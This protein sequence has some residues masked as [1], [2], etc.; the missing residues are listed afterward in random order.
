MTS[1]VLSPPSNH[2]RALPCSLYLQ[3]CADGGHTPDRWSRSAQGHKQPAGWAAFYLRSSRE[4]PVERER[5]NQGERHQKS[6]AIHT[7]Q[8][9][10]AFGPLQCSSQQ[11][12]N[13]CNRNKKPSRRHSG[14]RSL[15]NTL[16]QVSKVG[17]WLFRFSN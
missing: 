6:Q 12:S 10:D 13:S 17:Q 1:S 15:N 4:K 9:F 5:V 2:R 8:K 7:C 3:I 16:C 11:P 14:T